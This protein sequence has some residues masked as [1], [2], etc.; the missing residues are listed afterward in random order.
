MAG[1]NLARAYDL[2]GR[3]SQVLRIWSS[4]V[5]NTRWVA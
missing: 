2:G 3:A 5:V 4:G 1:R